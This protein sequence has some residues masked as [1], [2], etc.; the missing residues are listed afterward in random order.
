MQNVLVVIDMQHDFVD[1]ALGS[2]QAEAI[3]ANV[4][5]KIESFHGPIIFTRDT[6]DSHYLDSQEGKLLPVSHC[7]KGTDG[8][9]IVDGLIEAAESRKIMSPVS[10]IDKPNFASFELLSRLEGMHTVNPIESITL[11]GLCTDICVVSNALI[12]KAGL[13]EVP[14][15]VDASCCA[16]VTP[17]S[18]DAAL[19]TM[20]ACQCI[21]D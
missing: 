14:I 6:H 17:E 21:I 1:G 12:L 3:V 8:W 4:R 11:V 9:H 10:F 15:H 7:I 16:G 20:Q 13:P 5:K 2:P 18:H 19:K